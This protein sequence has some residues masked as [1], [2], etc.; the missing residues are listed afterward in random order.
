MKQEVTE[1]V[2]QD[3]VRE[4]VK[5][6]EDLG[7]DVITDGEVPRENYYLHFIRN[8]VRG[9]DLEV[10]SDKVMRDGAFVSQVPTVVSRVS[11]PPEP[12]CYKEFLAAQSSSSVPI[13]YTLPGPMTIM[14]GCYNRHYEDPR[15]LAKD[16]IIILQREV[17]ALVAH[18]CLHIQV[19]EPVLMRYPETALRHGVTDIAA[20]FSG[21][22]EKVNK[23]VH[24]CCG[25]PD[26]LEPVDYLKADNTN[27]SAV[28]KALDDAGI[29]WATIE[30]AE[31]RNDLSFMKNLNKLGIQLGVVTIARKKIESVEEITSRARSAL[32]FISPDRLM[33]TPDCGLGF[34]TYELAT[35]K[36]KNIVAAA[37]IINNS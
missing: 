4:V 35:E 21:C 19:D 26:R 36:I 25:Y 22:P 20:V 12:W 14:D 8:G 13:K 15:Q 5:V 29:N 18:G 33:L 31:R 30:D 1:Q 10:L 24:L 2:V 37:N 9:I 23:I 27:Y 3:K 17:L 34:L 28:L 32:E 16:I 11:S 7:L 6:Q